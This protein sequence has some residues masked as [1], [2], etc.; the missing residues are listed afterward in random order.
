MAGGPDLPGSVASFSVFVGTITRVGRPTSGG[1]PDVGTT[2]DSA[3]GFQ[4]Y[5]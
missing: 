4:V 2:T 3:M 5:R 1:F